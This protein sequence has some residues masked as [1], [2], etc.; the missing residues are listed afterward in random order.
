MKALD[1]LVSRVGGYDKVAHFSIG[2]WI[3]SASAVY[4]FK[5]M[6]ISF[7]AVLVLSVIKEMFLD[8]EFNLGDI[9]ATAL[10]MF[11]AMILYIPY[12][13]MME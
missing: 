9:A 7:V 6:A 4:G 3:L 10:G 11:L 5:W 1:K 13:A 12:D 8:D 2:G